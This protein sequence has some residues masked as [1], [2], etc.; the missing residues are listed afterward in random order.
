MQ[1]RNAINRQNVV[2]DPKENVNACDDFLT[3]V[4]TCHFLV[5]IMKKLGMSGLDDALTVGNFTSDS[6]MMSDDDRRTALYQFCQK[7]VADNVHL[8]LN[9][10][11][12][13]NI[14]DKV[15]EY[16]MEVMSLG[17]IYLNYKDAIQHGDG[18][19]F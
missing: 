4:V 12:S 16:A 8:P 10:V 17:I 19:G 5:V 9:P 15:Q 18:G 14:D 6:W 13:D 7:I 11:K 1:L 2:N 3:L